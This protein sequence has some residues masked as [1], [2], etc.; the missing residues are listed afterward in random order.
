MHS[1]LSSFREA[2]GIPV[3]VPL[4]GGIDWS[5]FRLGPAPVRMMSHFDRMGQLDNQPISLSDQITGTAAVMAEIDEARR[6]AGLDMV[7]SNPVEECTRWNASHPAGTRVKTSREGRNFYGITQ[8]VPARV[9]DGDM[10]SVL[11]TW[12]YGVAGWARLSGLHPLDLTLAEDAVFDWNSRHPVGTSLSFSDEMPFGPDEVG[13]G[14]SSG[15]AY[16]GVGGRALV[17]AVVAGTTAS[18][19]IELSDIT[20]T[21]VHERIPMAAHALNAGVSVSDEEEYDEIPENEIP[22]LD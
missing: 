16:V 13:Y 19:L 21:S 2:W 11:V 18:S 14:T 4:V 22:D 15:P 17:M 6:T 1:F 5:S 7:M 3:S 9:R 12:E 8:D 20:G 10:A